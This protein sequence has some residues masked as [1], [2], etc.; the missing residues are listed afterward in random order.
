[1][2]KFLPNGGLLLFYLCGG[3]TQPAVCCV[4]LEAIRGPW[5]RTL[6]LSPLLTILNQT[7]LPMTPHIAAER[8]SPLR[9]WSQTVEAT[10]IFR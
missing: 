5:D 7:L 10:T 2:D 3:P 9:I 8:L 4:C 1:M 6:C